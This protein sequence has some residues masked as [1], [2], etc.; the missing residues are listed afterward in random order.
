MSEEAKAESP[1]KHHL[2]AARSDQPECEG[3]SVPCKCVEAV[4]AD[5]HK[6]ICARR[7]NCYWQKKME[8]NNISN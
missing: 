7:V 5:V 2:D 6:W 8:R 3:E 1:F 4:E